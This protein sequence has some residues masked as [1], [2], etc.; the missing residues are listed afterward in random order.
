MITGPIH[1]KEAARRN[2]S[3][4]ELR[5]NLRRATG[6]SVSLRQEAVSAVPEWE[7]LRAKAHAIKT[8]AIDHLAEYLERF[9]SKA[10]EAGCKVYWAETASQAV[11]YVVNICRQKSASL[12]VKAKSMTSE[13]MGLDA[14]LEAA[15]IL[16][17][18][19]DLGEFIIQLAGETPSHITAPALHKSRA[20]IGKLFSEKLG[21][22]F[23]DDP[24]E[25]TRS[26]RAALKQ[27]FLQ[28]TIGIT[29]VNFAAADTGSIVLITNEG[30][31]RM[32]TTLPTTHIALMGIEKVIPRFDDLSVFLKLLAR[33]S[34]GQ[35]LTSYVT[36]LNGP[37]KANEMDGPYEL[38]VIIL[39]NGR[40]HLLAHPHTREALYCLRCGACLNVCPVYQRVGGHTY[41]W[42][43]PGPIGSVITPELRG[44]SHAQE[45]PFAS[46]LCGNCSAVCPVKIDLHHML[47]WLRKSAVDSDLTSWSER[48]VM[49]IFA[50]MM[51]RPGL[52]RLGR[53]LGWIAQRILAPPGKGLRVPHWSAGR[54][55]PPLAK[56]SFHQLWEEGEIH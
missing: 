19:T 18:E 17:V 34:T 36:I 15:G 10:R 41:G 6:H 55:F 37:R 33:S 54:D 42:V 16:P 12:A 21:T 44:I 9:E 23:S 29:G 14:A 52:Y 27:K 24:K 4:Q 3:A 13:E 8:E 26:A 25:L 31:G 11:D 5:E 46:S 49:R 30:N 7:E 56:K 45:L 47:L 53:T 51:K 32:C 35:K 1:F 39:D 43:Y 2:L 50:A 40:S 38:H 20:Q 28:A 48:W 22:N